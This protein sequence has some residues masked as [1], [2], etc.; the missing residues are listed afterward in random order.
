MDLA[1]PLLLALLLGVVLG[2]LIGLLVGRRSRST[3]GAEDP[4][5]VEMRHQ[6]E[7]AGV[8]A[9]EAAVRNQLDR[10]HLAR[11][12]AESVRSADTN[13]RLQA[14]VTGL[15][16]RLEAMSDE[17]LRH[18]ERY[19]NLVERHR[20][21]AELQKHRDAAENRVLQVLTPVQE[22][23]RTMQAKVA[24]IESQRSLQH[25]EITQQLRAAAD[26]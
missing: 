2:A 13:A 14:Q 12:N 26:S 17:V 19:R 20:T 11:A 3:D 7:I 21:D 22:T 1:L 8:R 25:G 23:L 9:E 6:N 15:S 10:E 4:R 18:E 16:A 5:L 24:E